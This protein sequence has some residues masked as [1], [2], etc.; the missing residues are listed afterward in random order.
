MTPEQIL[1]IGTRGQMEE[2]LVPQA[3][4]ALRTI[5][6][7]PL[8]G[9]P[10]RQ[11][12]ANSGR[13]ALGLA[14]AGQLLA[15]FRP[16]ILF[17][18]GGYVNVPVALAARLRRIPALIFLPDV[19]P[20]AA[21]KRLGRLAAK[22]A[23][24]VEASQ[25][26][27]PPGKTVVTGYPVR[28]ELRQALTLSRA[29]ARAAFDLRMDE[30]VVFVFGGSRGAWSINQALMAVLPEALRE[31]QVIHVSGTLTWPQ[32]DANRQQL[33]GELRA[34]YRAFPYLQAEMGAAF[35]AADL[36]VARAG[37]SML[38]EGPAFGLPAILV[39]YPHAWRY[40]KVNADYLVERG[41]ALRLNDEQMSAQFWPMLQSLL[42]Q[43]E[44]LAAL[45]SAARALDQPAAAANLARLML[46]MASRQTGVKL[47]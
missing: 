43:P 46:E 32:V 33:P 36:V 25:A 8:A 34:R 24:S 6:G 11:K 7:G 21:I 41:A 2:T 31:T 29:E 37:A 40:Q 1:W 3:G 19:E 23:C 30:P 13:L 28:E 44:R 35:R 4:V 45:G 17:M 47:A 27:F 38:G 9:V 18:T 16:D 22:V 10:W 14:Q 12:I 20:G 42:R 26:Y 5:P 15:M 39:P